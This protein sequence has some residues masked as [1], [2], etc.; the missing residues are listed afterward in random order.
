MSTITRRL[1]PTIAAALTLPALAFPASAFAAIAQP[2]TTVAPGLAEAESRFSLAASRL[3]TASL[4]VADLQARI[5][6]LNLSISK[7]ERLVPRDVRGTVKHVLKVYASAFY[8]PYREQT[9]A[10][11]DAAVDI[12]RLTERRDALLTQL[13][14][15]TTAAEPLAE[16]FDGSASALKAAEKVEAG[17]VA[18]EKVAATAKRAAVAARFGIFPVAGKNDYIDSWGFA[19]SGGRRHKGTDIM[20]AT[21][22]PVVAVRDGAVTSK[23]SSL[24]GL[25]IWLTAADGTRYYYAH[26]SSATRTSGAVKAGEVIGAVGSSGNASASAPHLHFEIHTPVAVDPHPYLE[27][28]VS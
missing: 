9:G 11:E 25:T 23:T 28:M 16:E 2:S 8:G 5:A 26:L 20:A 13:D 15:A 22:T 27:K 3:E 6:T 14:A 19:R 17:R 24:G 7:S 12:T 18:A 1:A 4:Q 21:G 10:T